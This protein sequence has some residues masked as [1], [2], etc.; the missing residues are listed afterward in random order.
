MHSPSKTPRTT[1]TACASSPSASTSRLPRYTPTLIPNPNTV[2]S[3]RVRGTGLGKGLGLRQ[4]WTRRVRGADSPGEHG[5]TRALGLESTPAGPR[6][7]GGRRRRPGARQPIQEHHHL[8]VQPARLQ[9]LAGHSRV[10]ARHEGDRGEDQ[11]EDPSAFDAHSRPRDRHAHRHSGHQP[12]TYGAR[13][14]SPLR[15]H[16][17]FVERRP[18]QSSSTWTKIRH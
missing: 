11:H 9:Q 5:V 18:P 7:R 12:G 3:R 17:S 6:R 14:L 2:L 16:S 10:G 8:K 1:P 15:C 4:G 13:V